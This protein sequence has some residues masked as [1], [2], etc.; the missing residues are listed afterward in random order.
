MSVDSI[1]A[2]IFILGL[3]VFLWYKRKKIEFQRILFPLLYVV[4]YRSTFGVKAM[5]KWAKRFPRFLIWLGYSGVVLGFAGM[6]LICASLIKST[7]DVLLKPEMVPGI[8]LVLPIEAKGV[9]FVPFLYWIISIFLLAVVH[10]FS[11]GVLS[12]VHKVKVKSSGFAFLCLLVPIIPAAFVEPEEKVL[13]KK[14][15]WKQLSVFA[16]GPISNVIFA[17]LMLLL[18][19]GSSSVLTAAFQPSGVELTS[20][21]EDG[22]AELAGLTEGAIITQINDV[23]ILSMV[24]LTNFLSTK[25][26]GEEVTVFA[27]DQLVKVTLSE[28]PKNASK[29]FLGIHATPYL[30]ENEEFAATYGVWTPPAIK[31]TAGLIFWLFILNLGIGLFNLIPIGPLDGGRMFQLL[32][33]KV[34]KKKKTALKVWGWTS[35][36]FIALIL[37]NILLGLFA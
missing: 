36:F 28:N 21:G 10:E 30:K 15:Y 16:A 18:F 25:S 7:I 4:L 26:P 2:I 1:A 17:A 37:G 32:C 34:F 5:D 19:F 6:A 33:F 3:I 31:W 12:R 20:I 22:P 11:H 35:T 23:P 29:G 14:G 9:F 24:N 27:D 13:Q 8:Q